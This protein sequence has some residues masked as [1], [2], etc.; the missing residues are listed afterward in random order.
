MLLILLCGYL[1][2]LLVITAL[3]RAR[4]TER[5]DARAF[6]VAR[7]SLPALTT[8]CSLTATSVGGSSTVVTT[9]LVQRHGLAGV[10]MDLAGALGF[11]ALGLLLARRVRQSG[12]CSIAELAG[13]AQGP[14]IR[15]LVAAVVLVAELAWLALL[16]RAT[17]SVLTPALPAAP[18]WTLLLGAAA[19]PALYT[20][21]GGQRAVSYTDVA[22]LLVMLLGLCLLAP[23][24]SALALRE[25][26]LVLPLDFPVS[27]SFGWGDVAAFLVL[28]GL[29]H[30]VGS[31]IYAKL[32]SARDGRAARRGALLAAGLKAAVAGA[33]AFTA[34]CGTRLL[35]GLERPE[36]LLGTLVKKVL[37][38]PVSALVTLALVAT[39]MSSA[40][41]V[42][43]S[44]VTML[45]N[46]L[47][48]GRP[49]V[50]PV[51]TLGLG[52]LGLGLAWAAPGVIQLMKV[53]YTIF[54]AGLALPVL[55][56]LA[57]G[58]QPPRRAVVAAVVLGGLC[59]AG[60][61]A[62]ALLG[63]PAPGDPVL[64]GAGLSAACLGAG[65]LAG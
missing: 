22:Q 35:P 7:G 38:G 36:L 62:A 19:V 30:L 61:H 32:L 49:A 28:G 57:P 26:V 64:W 41:Q 23:I 20:L 31:D 10:W 40:D 59:G 47:L 21:A 1:V 46:D 51:A 56:S 16:V 25:G 12:A 50:I 9:A 43:L 60:L 48:P 18:P 33:V 15:R 65:Y 5:R 42:L 8:A 13:Q 54:A 37:S 55:S 58:R 29:P 14:G 52:A 45:G 24:S 17:A 6:F 27:A 4:G 2:M 39:M 53:A 44:A 3:T 11:L 63:H 34:L